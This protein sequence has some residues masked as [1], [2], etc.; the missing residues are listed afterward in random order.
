MNTD[1]YME[2]YCA[3]TKRKGFTTQT[4][5]S[6]EQHLKSFF[7]FADLYYPRLESPATVNKRIV[8]DYHDYLC[9]RKTADG[10]PLANKSICAMLFAIKSFYSFLTEQDLIAT[11]P[12]KGLILPKQERRLIRDVLTEAEVIKILKSCNTSTPFG[13]RDRAILELVYATGIRTTELCNLK[14]ADVDLK[15]QTVFID[16]GKGNISRLVPAGQ[17]AIMYVEK[18]LQNGRRFFL[19]MKTQDPGY[20]FLT[21]F[22][23]PFDRKSINKWVL[24]P[25]Q[26]K[27]RLKKNITVY[28]FRHALATHLLQ[29]D[30]DVSYIGKLLGHRS[31]N[32]TQQYLKIEIGDLKRVHSLYHPRG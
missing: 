6:Y 9:E 19:K 11:D 5:E 27:L 8:A 21:Q 20:L 26:Q 3:F 13:L 12:T 29:H 30:V 23:N 1:E 25:I 17:Y 31:L 2:K 18:Y 32:T 7:T 14:V 15:E 28:S 10:K 24:R 22:G 4:Q 16:K